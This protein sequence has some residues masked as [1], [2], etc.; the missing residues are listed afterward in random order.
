MRG[1]RRMRLVRPALWAAMI[2]TAGTLLLTRVLRRPVAAW[3]DVPAADGGWALLAAAALVATLGLGGASLWHA[4][5]LPRLVRVRRID[6]LIAGLGAGMLLLAVTIVALVAVA[7]ALGRAALLLAMPLWAAGL[8]AAVLAM[9][10]LIHARASR[11]A[12]APGAVLIL[13]AGLRGREVG[14]LLR[15]RVER[16]AAVWRS[17]RTRR[18]DARIVVAGGQGPDEVRTEASAMAE[19]LERHLGVPADAIDLE[20]ASATTRENLRLSRPLVTGPGRAPLAVVTSE[21]HAYRTAWLLADEGIDGTVVGAWTRPSYRPGAVVREA[22]AVAS[23]LRWWC[24]AAAVVLE[25]LA[26]WLLVARP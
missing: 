1:G 9:A 21:Y 14:P 12:P 18:P 8:A 11:A 26:A 10:M 19:H 16:G 17:A 24:I 2:V 4:L 25:A 5:M 15:R 3:L 7:P 22:L 6:V 20:Q 23:D 13:G